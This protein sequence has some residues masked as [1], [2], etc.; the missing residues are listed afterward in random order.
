MTST[1]AAPPP[2]GVA[3]TAPRPSRRRPLVL[4]AVA[5]VVVVGLGVAGVATLLDRTATGPP[6]VPTPTTA[7]STPSAEPV[8]L[9]PGIDHPAAADVRAVL[10]GYITGINERRYA[11]AF[12][13]YSPDSAAAKGGLTAWTEAQSTSSITNPAISAA[14]ATGD[15]NA[16]EVD[17]R[18][19][20]TQDAEHGP[21][22]QTCTNW[23]LAYDMIDPGPGWLIR[24]ARALSPPRAC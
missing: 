14:R 11:D 18:F 4:G 13:F 2:T 15:P 23:E 3:G 20:S 16:V 6:V 10:G 5:A 21:N 19:I 9:D 7:P 24:G 22:G 17:V 1:Y 8:A 12:A